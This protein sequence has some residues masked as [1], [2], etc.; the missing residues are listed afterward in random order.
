MGKFI[1]KLERKFGKYAIHNLA[2]YIIGAYVIGYIFQFIG[3]AEAVNL[4]PYRIVHGEIWRII[5]WIFIPP[6]TASGGLDFLF[7]IIMLVF[8]YSLAQNLEQAWGAFR[9]NLYIFSGIIMTIIGAFVF[10]G[11]ME[12]TTMKTIASELNNFTDSQTAD[13]LS[14]IYG[15]DVTSLNLLKS[16]YYGVC[17]RYF[18]T[19]YINLS[20]FLAFAACFPNMQVMLYFVIPIKIKWLAYLDVA[21]LAFDI[22]QYAAAGIWVG[23]VA[24]V[25]SLLNFVVFFFSTR[26]MSRISPR[27]IHRK[28]VYKKQ[29]DS[30]RQMRIHRCS[31]CGRTNL[32][33]DTLEFR[34][35]SKCDGNHEYCQNH[36]FTHEHIKYQ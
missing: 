9:F 21:L 33:D 13:A 5:T 27:E 19:Y 12:L 7:V 32:D 4:N 2:L 31:I 11:I 25:A 36:L 8:Y 29:V 34:F 28:K 14:A 30:A 15:S 1:Y 3:V 22:Y 35:C 18:S 24:I 20:I 23:V 10:Y 6:R 26:N 16:Q 17:A